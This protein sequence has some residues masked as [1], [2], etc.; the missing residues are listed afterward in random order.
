MHYVQSCLLPKG[1]KT[2]TPMH[3]RIAAILVNRTVV[4]DF[5]CPG[6]PLALDRP[7]AGLY[8]QKTPCRS[9]LSYTPCLVLI[10]P[11][12]VPVTSMLIPSIRPL[13]P[14]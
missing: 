6:T 9:V 5:R 14:I 8:Q 12:A 4:S 11:S 1:T 3:G 7:Y 13:L 2:K 10:R